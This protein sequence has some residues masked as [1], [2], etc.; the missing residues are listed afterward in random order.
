M[1]VSLDEIMFYFYFLT[2]QDLLGFDDPAPAPAPSAATAS[3]EFGAFQASSAPT[4]AGASDEFAAFD[5]IRSA[6][7]QGPDPF[8]SA[9][10]QQQTASFDAFGNNGAGGA[11]NNMMNNNMM[12]NN[13]MNNNTM[14]NNNN[15]MNN[16]NMAAMGNAFG[17]MGVSTGAPAGGMQQFQ[18][19]T[20]AS[21]DD[22]FGDFADAK[23]ASS[24]SAAAKKSSDPFTGLI[25]LDSLSKNPSN[26]MTMNQPVAIN[27][28]AAQYQQNIQNGVQGSGTYDIARNNMCFTGIE[29]LNENKSS[30]S[31]MN[32]NL[33]NNLSKA[34]L[35][36]SAGGSDA[37]SSMFAPPPQQ[38]QQRGSNFSM[39]SQASGGSGGM[40]MNPQMQQQQQFNM[41]QG[42]QNQGMQGMMGGN[43]QMQGG[44]GTQMG[45]GGG[46]M[47]N[48]NTNMNQMGGQQQQQQ[49]QMNQMNPQM[50]GG[51]GMQGGMN[52]MG[53]MQ[54][55]MNQM[56]GQQQKNPQMMGNMGM[57][58][59]GGMGGQQQTY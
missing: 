15:M 11:N 44:F 35:V 56:G 7:G 54:G 16:N 1:F 8:A 42:M 10:V 22:D 45:G 12:N 37:I 47:N 25:N 31:L 18:Q 26:K 19:P 28:A 50:M 13:T 52:Q 23:A 27:A 46:M 2:V 58:M 55:G 48:T 20:P 17:N 14:N 4:P 39:N 59:Q 36:V 57:G 33:V 3:S 49:Q 5:Q 43:P 51:M 30:P 9:P 24:S 38:Q 29:G 53:G 34:P 6:K 41:N 21:N 40:P 32:P